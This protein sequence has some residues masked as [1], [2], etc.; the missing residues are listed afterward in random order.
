MTQTP[1]ARAGLVRLLALACLLSCA[2][3]GNPSSAR[4]RAPRP[5]A[6]A[7]RVEGVDVEH[8][9]LDLSLEP[10]ERWLEGTCTLTLTASAAVVDAFELDLVGLDVFWV[11]DA[12]GAPLD[13]R[14]AD[15]R[16]WIRPRRPLA[17]GE[18]LEVT[19]SYGGS[20]RKGLWFCA[21]RE[22]VPTQVFT[23]G[24][25][26]DAR[27]WFP[28][29]DYPAERAT[30]E[31][32]VTMPE[33]WTSVAAGELI[34]ERIADGGRT[35]H[36]RMSAPHPS[37][38]VTL[39]AGEF[40]V[41]ED[42]WDGIPLATMAAPEHAAWME[43]AFDQTDEI[44]AFLTEVTGRRYP[45]AKY[46]QAC[47]ENF[48]FGGMENIS[49]T[50]LTAAT[51]TDERG[52]RD[53]TS[54][55]LVAHEAAHQWFGD[56]LTCANWSHIWLN[57][58]FATYM[59]ALYFERTLGVDDFRVR[60][61]DAQRSY[62][63]GDVGNGRRPT[64]HDV[65]REPMDLFFGGHTYAGGAARLHLLRRELGDEAF[66]AGVRRYVADN[67]G[68]GVVTADLRRAMELASGRDLGRFFEQWLHSPGFPELEVEWSWTE[69]RPWVDLVVRQVQ[70][71]S[72]GTPHSFDLPLDV[73]VMGAAGA[74]LHELRV[75]R[76]EHRFTL[77]AERRPRW[78]RI[79][80]H[81][82]VPMR[83]S[84]SRSAAEWLAIAEADDDVNGRRDAVA[85]LGRL[86]AEREASELKEIL[87]DALIERLAGDAAPAVRVAAARALGAYTDGLARD[88][89]AS[90]AAADP[91]ASVRAAALGALASF[92]PEDALAE[93]ARGVFEEGYSWGV[94]K[95]AAGLLVSADPREAAA[96]IIERLDTPSPHGVLEAGLV[97]VL[98]R[99]SGGTITAVLLERARDEDAPQAVR[100]AA[101]TAL[102]FRGFGDDDVRACL[103]GLLDTRL[104]R[105]RQAAVAALGVL[106]DE[107]ARRPLEALYRRSV[108][109]RERRSLE[110]ILDLVP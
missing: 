110:R 73:E 81:G 49:A 62:M 72:D 46:S 88:G 27:Y 1:R 85:A 28:C 36:W 68:R 92:G 53:R 41:V 11:R 29:M 15:G 87:R 58:G 9:F 19:V 12:D 5:A 71:T 52:R 26:E 22:G 10:A 8:L 60:M 39:V 65:Y 51:L 101:A 91:R 55:G 80:K 63:A 20:P 78:V 61:R 79:D 66:F 14:H 54:H 23:Q 75:E 3:R 96:W 83:L 108:F 104:Y 37:Y 90:A 56:L 6:H 84:V 76:R 50:T 64:V 95:A 34:A 43:A 70:S 7:P 100:S 89:L 82:W 93:L 103:V 38:L 67:A 99:M 4:L 98:G 16:L 13:H 106:D 25:C 102:G 105:L 17:R 44:L 74:V 69:E 97:E 94:M 59:T 24:E 57:E 42:V 109:P 21:E 30:S 33:H 35:H 77:P 48:P 86:A 31:L 47:V 18:Q 107:R 45:Y 2:C 32:R 40:A